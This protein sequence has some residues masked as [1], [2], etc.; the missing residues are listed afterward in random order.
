MLT[1][2]QFLSTDLVAL[3]D[4]GYPTNAGKK[5]SDWII[6]AKAWAGAKEAYDLLHGDKPTAAGFEKLSKAPGGG[7]VLDALVADL[8][9]DIPQE[10]LTAAVQ[11]RYGIVVKQYDHRDGKGSGGKRAAANPKT[12][13]KA[14]KGPYSVLG[15]VP[16]KDTAKVKSIDRYT[17]ETGGAAYGG[18]EIDLYCGRPGDGKVQELNTPGEVMPAGQ[19]A[20]PSLMAS[21]FGMVKPRC[22][23]RRPMCC[24]PGLYRR[25]HGIPASRSHFGIVVV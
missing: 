12:P 18:G 10:V 22:S 7:P 3:A 11:A 1:G 4:S 17:E 16:L 13:D 20:W 24:L 14:L 5:I 21:D 25:P 23:N 6:G 8:P 19:K 2:S 15:K 9:D